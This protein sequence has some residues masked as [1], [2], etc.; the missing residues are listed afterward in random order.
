[1][2]QWKLACMH[3]CKLVFL[4]SWIEVELLDHVV[5]LL[6][7]FWFFVLF[8]FVF[9]FLGPHPQQVEVPGLG[10]ELELWLQL[11]A[12]TT[13]TATPDWSCVCDLHHSSPQCWIVS[14]LSEAWDW[15]C[16][17]MDPSQIHFHWATVGAPVF[18]FLRNLHTVFHSLFSLMEKITESLIMQAEGRESVRGPETPKD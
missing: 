17:L 14:P 18:S 11:P 8:C 1:M 2:L 15:T 5:V 7:G 12:Y 16:I 4:V 13:A 10:V 9:C 6:L 3:L